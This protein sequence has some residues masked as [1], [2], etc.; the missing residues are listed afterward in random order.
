MP[1]S[2]VAVSL[3]DE[4]GDE[5][6]LRVSR[7]LA[8]IYTDNLAEPVPLELRELIEALEDRYR[9]RAFRKRTRPAIGDG[10]ADH[11]F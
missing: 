3:N 8:S 4:T 10:A 2:R 9:A 11:E 7:E 5:L 1:K 6:R